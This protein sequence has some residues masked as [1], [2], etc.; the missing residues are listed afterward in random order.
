MRLSRA[1]TNAILEGE[2]PVWGRTV[3][4]ALQGAIVLS[5]TSIAIETL[6]GLPIWLIDVLFWLEIL[7][8]VLF[9]SEYLLRL[10]SAPSRRGY[11]LSFWGIIDL[12]A[13]LPS[14][15]LLTG[16]FLSLRALR[17]LR[18]LRL[19]KLLRYSQALERIGRA[20][21]RVAP[22]MAVYGLVSLILLYLAAVGI[23]VL[24]HKAQP[25]TFGSIPESFYWAVATLTTV[26]YGD[27][28][29]VTAGGRAFTI[30]VLIVGLGIIAVPT[31]LVATALSDET[32]AG[33]DRPN[34]D[35]TG[36]DRE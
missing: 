13:V 22:E 30:L 14:I 23:Y 28:Y 27:I 2:D 33:N 3:A 17:L 19:F 20:F 36:P 9:A 1:R 16:G 26:G 8:V 4:F 15:L 5:A 31:G 10:W 11:A 21:H 7:F 12:L 6:P 34:R 32:V 24:E 18:L 35:A 29:P 25:E